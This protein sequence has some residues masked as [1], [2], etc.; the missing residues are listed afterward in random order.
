MCAC[1]FPFVLRLFIF[2]CPDFSVYLSWWQCVVLDLM[3]F[4]E[5]ILTF[6]PFS[7]TVRGIL[8]IGTVT[9]FHRIWT[10]TW[11][12][13]NGCVRVDSEKK[14]VVWTLLC[15][16]GVIWT[17][18]SETEDEKWFWATFEFLR[19][20]CLHSGG[21]SIMNS[22]SISKFSHSIK[23]DN[24]FILTIAQSPCTLYV[25]YFDCPSTYHSHSE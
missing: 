19:K 23:N 5:N 4:I 12:D 8:E 3:G 15:C 17:D 10:R 14:L 11:T 9:E 20:F 25:L 7:V 2:R 13:T 21:V 22:V 18:N 6:S 24:I 16:S 1:F